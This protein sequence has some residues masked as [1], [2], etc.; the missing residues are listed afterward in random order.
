MN[1]FKKHKILLFT[2][3]S[4]IILAG[5]NFFMIYQIITI[6]VQILRV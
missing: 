6:G 2:I 5:L 3:I 4:F 1:F